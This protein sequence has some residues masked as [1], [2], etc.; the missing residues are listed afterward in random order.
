MV[1]PGSEIPPWFVHQQEG[2]YVSVRHNECVGIAL[3]F[4]LISYADPYEECCYSV[5]CSFT[6]RIA[7][8]DNSYIS[9]RVLPPMKPGCPH[10]YI[11]F[12]TDQFSDGFH[13]SSHF[14]LTSICRLPK[15]VDLK[16]VRCG[17]RLVREQ[18][19]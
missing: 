5:K 4:L 16:I 12:L 18:D 7:G 11:L 8:P 15:L 1:I 3:C 13:V 19:V 9:E 17:A 2:R 14:G 10:L 6:G